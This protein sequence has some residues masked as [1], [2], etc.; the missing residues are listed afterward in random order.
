MHEVNKETI[1]QCHN[2]IKERAQVSWYSDYKFLMEHN[3]H[4]PGA[5]HLYMGVSHGGKS[6]LIRS[7]IWDALRRCPADKKVL[8]W[9]SEETEHD[10]LI[11]FIMAGHTLPKDDLIT[12]ISKLLIHSE[13]KWPEFFKRGDIEN[14]NDYMR[15]TFA[16]DDI[17]I[18][19]YDNITT[20]EFYCDNHPSEQSTFVWELKELISNVK[21]PLILVAHTASEISENT[22]RF[23]S[24]TDIRG[25]KTIVN[26]VQFFYILQR[27][28]IEDT[29]FPT[30][31]ILK[32]RGQTVKDTMYYLYFDKEKNIYNKDKKI[33]FNSI[34]EAFR[35]RNVL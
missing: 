22:P 1:L 6:T 21:T 33:D 20:S 5:I 29:Y 26:L 19:F 3:G 17:D 9:L 11:E 31:R 27:F 8:V 16:R 35:Q 23:I 30:L 14:K 34:K 2:L 25:S 7:L 13:M 12:L 28:S 10:F 24:M 18:I 4:R 15:E 32:H